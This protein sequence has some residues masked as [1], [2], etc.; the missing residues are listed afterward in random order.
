MTFPHDSQA[1]SSRW[2]VVLAGV[3]VVSA[4]ALTL[5]ATFGFIEGA[6]VGLD[7]S[8]K[9]TTLWMFLWATATIVPVSAAIAI[10]GCAAATKWHLGKR[11][12][13]QLLIFAGAGLIWSTTTGILA[14]LP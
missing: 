12:A 6:Q 9:D 4:V 2:R 11:L 3:A 10:I 14:E 7:D 8:L 13:L 5:A 1:I